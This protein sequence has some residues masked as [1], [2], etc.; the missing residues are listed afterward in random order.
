VL[1]VELQAD[2][3]GKVFGCKRCGEALWARPRHIHTHT[4]NSGGRS[5]GLEPKIGFK[6]S[7][8]HDYQ[9]GL[10]RPVMNY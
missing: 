6:P 9:L 1:L 10:G 2:D 8:V 4:K 7:N 3:G 5:R